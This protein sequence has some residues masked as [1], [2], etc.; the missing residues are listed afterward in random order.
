MNY[1]SPIAV[2]Y[3]HYSYAGDKAKAATLKE[4][5]LTLSDKAEQTEEVRRYF[6]D[7]DAK[8]ISTVQESPSITA[9]NIVIK[10]NPAHNSV[11]FDIP[12]TMTTRIVIIDMQGNIMK[13]IETAGTITIPI[14]DL[15]N[16]NYTVQFF[17]DFGVLS[18]N[19][20]IV[21]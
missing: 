5:A 2:L 3:E 18:K 20:V 12:S 21:R 10:P 16:G 6:N 9:S 11:T 17:G 14:T 13:E 4:F 1:I 19:L 8:T 7:I 15:I